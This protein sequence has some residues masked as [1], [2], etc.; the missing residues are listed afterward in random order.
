MRDR[1]SEILKR[2]KEQKGKTKTE[3]D[4]LVVQ[5]ASYS[6]GGKKKKIEGDR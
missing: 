6:K 5:S 2:G 4:R 1:E 3:G